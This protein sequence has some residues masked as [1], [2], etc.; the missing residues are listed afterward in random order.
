MTIENVNFRKEQ[1]AERPIEEYVPKKMSDLNL[2]YS[3]QDELSPGG[4]GQYNGATFNLFSKNNNR[5]TAPVVN[6]NR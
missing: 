2:P 4:A 1:A 3:S 6:G 5:T